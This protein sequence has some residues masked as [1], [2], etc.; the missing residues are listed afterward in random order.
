MVSFTL[1]LASQCIEN[2]R[3]YSCKGYS[4]DFALI[5]TLGSIYY[6]ITQV[7]D[8]NMFGIL[9]AL[10]MVFASSVSYVQTFIYPNEKH[11]KLTKWGI[12]AVIG[13]TIYCGVVELCVGLAES[14]ISFE[15]LATI[16]LSITTSVVYLYQ[17]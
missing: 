6:L 12:G 2:Y 16:L 17:V 9:F 15:S 5:A 13:F 3:N 10:A 1:C 11:N 4:S 8:P 7:Q 14:M